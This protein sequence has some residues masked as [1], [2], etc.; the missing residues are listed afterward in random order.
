[1]KKI[2]ETKSVKANTLLIFAAC[3]NKMS[4]IKRNVQSQSFNTFREK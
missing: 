2:E 1:M 4:Q 3:V